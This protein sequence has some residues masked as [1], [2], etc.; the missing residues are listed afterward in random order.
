V[1]H[2][3]GIQ[4][5]IGGGLVKGGSFFQQS[6][7]GASGIRGV[8]EGTLLVPR[9]TVPDNFLGGGQPDYEPEIL[10]DGEVCGDGDEAATSG[11]DEAGNAEERAEGIALLLAKKSFSVLGEDLCDLAAFA[12]DYQPVCID[13][14]SLKGAG[15]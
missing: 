15:D 5:E 12:I 11:D 2:C 10:E 13:K 4:L 8:K 3:A 6:V 7:D 1:S 14:T 9:D